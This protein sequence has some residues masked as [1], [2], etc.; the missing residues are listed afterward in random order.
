MFNLEG[1]I[2]KENHSD[3]NYVGRFPNEVRNT[4]LEC[5]FPGFGKKLEGDL[6]YV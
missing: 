3:I 1:N 4:P 6:Y 2:I 5:V